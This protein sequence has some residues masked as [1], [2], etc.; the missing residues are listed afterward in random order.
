MSG[1]AITELE[2]RVARLLQ[3]CSILEVDAANY[4]CRVKWGENESTW[5]PWVTLRAGKD[6]TWWAPEVG[7]GCLLLSPNGETNQGLV[8]PGIAY[9]DMPPP[10]L[11]PDVSRTEYK[12]GTSVQYDRKASVLTVDCVGD[13]VVKGAKT[14]LVQFQGDVTVKSSTQVTIDAPASTVTGSLHI[15]GPV[16]FDA[17]MT[18]SGDVVADGVS[19][20]SH[21]HGG[22]KAGTDHSGPP[23]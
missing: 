22:V 12:D 18:G 2:L 4:V 8:L 10:A 23:G 13:V 21:T 1:Y 11:D 3:V 9:D 16:T 14:L 15:E 6:R 17:G 20:E 7:E 19:L 5:L